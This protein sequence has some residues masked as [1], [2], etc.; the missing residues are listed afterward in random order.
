MALRVPHRGLARRATLIGLAWAV[1]F[2]ALPGRAVAAEPAGEALRAFALSPSTEPGPRGDYQVREAL[3]RCGIDARYV[4]VLH[5]VSRITD[6][7]PVA[8]FGEASVT[9]CPGSPLTAVAFEEA[10]ASADE[11]VAFADYDAALRELRSLREQLPCLMDTVERSKLHRLHL[12]EGVAQ[13]FGGD[14]AAAREAF[15]RAVAVDDQYPWGSEFGPSAQEVHVQA[16]REVLQRGRAVLQL[17]WTGVEPAVWVDGR[18]LEVIRGRAGVELPAGPHLLQVF[19]GDA[20]MYAAV[21]EVEGEVVAI[22]EQALL[23]GAV[24]LAR[25]DSG[26]VGI[27]ALQALLAWM[28]EQ[29]YGTGWLVDPEGASGLRRPPLMR[30]DALRGQLLP[31]PT[32]ADRFATLPWLRHFNLDLGIMFH[33]RGG[34][35]ASYGKVDLSVMVPALPNMGAGGSLGIARLWGTDGEEVIAIPARARIRISP[36]FGS[37]RPFFDVALMVMWLKEADCS[38]FLVGGEAQVG[39]VVRPFRSKRFGFGGGAAAGYVGGLVLE[40]QIEAS[41]QW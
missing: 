12:L 39:V 1:A 26:G 4:D 36:D 11:H 32:L 27:P 22:Q 25:G 23:D 34:E 5:G 14:R 16:E 6:E 30:V 7:A 15:V 3:Y 41:M 20:L 17:G 28:E 9:R 10:L 19:D 8:F 13:A 24:A 2:A 37:V 21:L 29:R 18:R 31:P 35:F 38:P 33:R 40:V